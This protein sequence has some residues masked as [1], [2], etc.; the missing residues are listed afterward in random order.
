MIRAHTSAITPGLHGDAI[1]N[2][3]KQMIATRDG[4]TLFA[5]KFIWFHPR[6]DLGEICNHWLVRRS[7]PDFDF[8]DGTRLGDNMKGGAWVVIDFSQNG[9]IARLVKGLE[10]FVYTGCDAKE[11]LELQVVLIR[12]DGVV[13]WVT[14]EKN[15]DVVS[16]LKEA[17]AR[18]LN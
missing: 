18:W 2:L 8:T 13:A 11:K 3:A 16:E 14:D 17:R 10:G 12:P 7:A 5:S 1:Y 9:D 15:G 6:I 4:S